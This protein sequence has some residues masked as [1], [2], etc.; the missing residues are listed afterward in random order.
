MVAVSGILKTKLTPPTARTDSIPRPRLT[1]QF[2]AGLE[3]P[4]TLICAPAGYGKTT[5]LTGWL[6]SVMGN[7]LSLAWLSLDD[8]DNDP[9]RFLSYVVSALSATGTIDGNEV[10]AHLRSPQSPSPKTIVTEL[11]S[12]LETAA[13]RIVLILDDYHCI[14]AQ[15][16]HDAVTFLLDHLP[17]QMRLVITSRENPPFPLARLRARAACRDSGG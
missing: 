3:R 12:L 11:I 16:I 10:L 1:G 4:L 6:G 9:A 8:D 17:A 14:T 2:S 7:E 13:R 5:L 15:P